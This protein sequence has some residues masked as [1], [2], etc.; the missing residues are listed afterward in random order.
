MKTIRAQA[1]SVSE[2]LSDVDEAPADGN[3]AAA[4]ARCLKQFAQAGLMDLGFL[5]EGGLKPGDIH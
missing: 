2:Q 4:N 3:L 1:R 5:S